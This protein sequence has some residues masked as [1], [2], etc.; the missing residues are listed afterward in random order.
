MVKMTIQLVI[1]LGDYI[2]LWEEGWFYYLGEKMP[3]KMGTS[4]GDFERE[5]LFYRKIWCTMLTICLEHFY[6]FVQLLKMLYIGICFILPSWEQIMSIGTFKLHIISTYVELFVVS[7]FLNYCIWG[8]VSSCLVG[9]IFIRVGDK[10]CY[11]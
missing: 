1:C 8:C 7:N 4:K 2:I 10:F 11:Y 9:N 3:T 5:I 6:F